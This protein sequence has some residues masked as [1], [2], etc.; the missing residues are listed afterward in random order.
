MS[1]QPGEHEP[2]GRRASSDRAVGDQ[3]PLGVGGQRTRT[4]DAALPVAGR[5]HGRR[6]GV[7]SRG[8]CKAEGM[9][10]GRPPGCMPPD[11]QKH[12]PSNSALERTSTTVTVGLVDGVLNTPGGRRGRPGVLEHYDAIAGT[13]AVGRDTP[14][15][16][17]WPAARQVSR[18]QSRTCTSRWPRRVSSQNPKAGASPSK[19]TVDSG[20]I[21]EPDSRAAP[22]RQ[23]RPGGIRRSSSPCRRPTARRHRDATRRRQPRLTSTSTS[24]RSSSWEMRRQ[25]AV[26]HQC[27]GPQGRPRSCSRKTSPRG[28]ITAL[29]PPGQASLEEEVL[30]PGRWGNVGATLAAR[31]TTSPAGELLDHRLG[32]DSAWIQLRRSSVPTLSR[33]AGWSVAMCSRMDPDDLIICPPRG[34]RSRTRTG[35]SSP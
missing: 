34:L 24:R 17:G 11:G 26:V 2:G 6:R 19:T 1:E 33:S 7:P 23:A 15:V 35:S 25:P 8:W 30:R 32:G 9:W 5:S 3:L 10:P 22:M 14:V 13:G 18:E 27:A 31:P 20:P 21:P 16:H 4:A 12:S 28:S 29:L